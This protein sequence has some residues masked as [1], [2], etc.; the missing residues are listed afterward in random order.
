VL[1]DPQYF[2][3][4]LAK[5][6]PNQP[7]TAFIPLKFS[8]PKRNIRRWDGPMLRAPMPKTAVHENCNVLFSKYEVRA[9]KNARSP[10]PTGDRVLTE[11]HYNRDLRIFVLAAAN[12]R[13]DFRPL[14]LVEDICHTPR[15]QLY[16][17]M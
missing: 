7:I 11:K 13:H 1:P 9:S 5:C 12:P 4:V 2:P 14:C 6:F 8:T 10:A 3:T 17:D 16:F 15:L